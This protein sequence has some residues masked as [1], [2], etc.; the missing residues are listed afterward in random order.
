MAPSNLVYLALILNLFFIMTF[1]ATVYDKKKIMNIV[2]I[3]L[4]P[5]LADINVI[6]NGSG[7][8]PLTHV[9]RPDSALSF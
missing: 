2:Q 3:L 1:M 9:N 8:E 5:D 4:H 6:F 7:S